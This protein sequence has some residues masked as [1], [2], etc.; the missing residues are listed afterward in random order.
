M[1][2]LYPWLPTQLP[3][4]AKNQ[5]QLLRVDPTTVLEAAKPNASIFAHQKIR[6]VLSYKSN[7]LVLKK[8]RSF[9]CFS[10]QEVFFRL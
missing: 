7:V 2:H 8:A 3:H 10:S 1:L 9:F 4:Q 6:Y 5:L